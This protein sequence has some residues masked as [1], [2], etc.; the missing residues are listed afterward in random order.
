MN[1]LQIR[2]KQQKL[3][4]RR[5]R[6]R[7]EDAVKLVDRAI[8]T[9]VCA[10]MLVLIEEFGFGVHS[11]ENSRL[12]RFKKALQAKTDKAAD[13]YDDAVLEGLRAKLE[14]RGVDY[15]RG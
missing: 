13:F 14:D 11:G 15:V 1:C 2:G 4:S 3:E 12:L 6:E 8:D 10:A 5:A 9:M 7:H